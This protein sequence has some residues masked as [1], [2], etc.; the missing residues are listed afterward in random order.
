M[1]WIISIVMFSFCMYFEDQVQLKLSSCVT[2]KRASGNAQVSRISTLLI[3]WES[4]RQEA[5]QSRS[6]PIANPRISYHYSQCFVLLVVRA[7]LRQL[8][9]IHTQLFFRISPWTPWRRARGQFLHPIERFMVSHIQD[10]IL[11]AFENFLPFHTSHS[12]L[13]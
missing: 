12:C 7:S 3:V 13:L 2:V 8:L 9:F 6:K 10:Q 11:S 4:T 1:S 5:I